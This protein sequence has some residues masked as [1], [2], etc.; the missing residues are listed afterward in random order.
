MTLGK[1]LEG[2]DARLLKAVGVCS[3]PVS[4]I[5]LFVVFFWFG[6]LKLIDTSP[7][8]PLVENL[9]EA[10]LPFVG[11][12]QFIVFLGLFEITIGIAFLVSG[13]ERLAI[14]LLVPHMVVTFLPLVFLRELT[15][16]GFL[17]PTLEGQYII[18]NLVI[19][20]LALA[21]AAHLHP[22]RWG[23]GKAP[24]CRDD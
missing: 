4:R 14:G 7:A 20:A 15:W 2:I 3:S 17:I 1:R 9:L 12:S 21:V 13:W 8:N 5:A 24:I 18:K 22:L 23:G 11:F 19:V 16:Q 6:A 10:T